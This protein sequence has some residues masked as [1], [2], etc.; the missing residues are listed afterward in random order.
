MFPFLSFS[1]HTLPIQLPPFLLKAITFALLSQRTS[2][3]K[4]I[5]SAEKG[6]NERTE[7]WDE[8]RAKI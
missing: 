2:R 8:E 3:N 5:Y 7:R 1:L 4:P 6:M